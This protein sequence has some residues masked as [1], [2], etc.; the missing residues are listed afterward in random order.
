M[1]LMKSWKSFENILPAF[2]GVLALIGLVLMILTPEIISKI[3]G[4]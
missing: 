2:A 4:A 3:I 1:A